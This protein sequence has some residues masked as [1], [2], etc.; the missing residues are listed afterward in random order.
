M[1]LVGA[2]DQVI[3]VDLEVHPLDQ[4]LSKYEGDIDRVQMNQPTDEE[5]KDID[6]FSAA[7]YGDGEEIVLATEPD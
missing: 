4:S 7:L 5:I 1:A 6:E 2:N 3:N